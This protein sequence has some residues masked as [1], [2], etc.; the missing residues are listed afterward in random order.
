MVKK[1]CIDT[2]APV[3][4]WITRD[5]AQLSEDVCSLAPSLCPTISVSSQWE[6]IRKKGREERNGKEA[7]VKRKILILIFYFGQN[8]IVQ[9]GPLRLSRLLGGAETRQSCKPG[10]SGPCN[11]IGSEGNFTVIASRDETALSLRFIQCFGYYFR[12]L[13]ER[14]DLAVSEC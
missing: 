13:S 2:K 4:L 11:W 7:A 10:Q 6:E 9:T 5:K 3:M 8:N 12:P 1:G 14:N